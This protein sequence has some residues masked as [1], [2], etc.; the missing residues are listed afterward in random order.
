MAVRDASNSH[1]AK[2]ASPVS[3]SVGKLRGE[4]G[5][6]GA[7]LELL[8]FPAALWT[9]DRCACVFNASA[10]RLL[11]YSEDDFS[12]NAA[13][14]STRLHPQDRA[15]FVNAWRKIENGQARVSYGY[16]FLPNHA[17]S[18]IRLRE[19]LFA[20][21]SP[22]GSPAVWS[23]YQ[24]DDGT[25][26]ETPKKSL[27]RIR[28]DLVRD[29]THEIGSNLQA[30]GGEVD[31]LRLSGRLPQESAQVVHRGVEQ[32]RR[33]V[34]DVSEYIAPSDVDRQREDT[35]TAILHVLHTVASRLEQRGIRVKVRLDDQLP[36]LPLGAVFRNAFK[37]VIEFTYTL[38]PTGGDLLVEAAS[39]R[40]RDSRY[41]E[42][43][44]INV[45]PTSLD[46][47][48]QNVFRPYLTVNDCR[49]GLTMSL[50]REIL[51]HHRGKITFK[52]ERR[53]R[54]VFSIFIKVPTDLQR[55]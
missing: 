20:Y 52:K 55:P 44:V 18:R 8:P 17:K 51:R 5:D 50:A 16:R 45:S 9:Y 26:D 30:I 29:L 34:S 2:A 48:D 24:E 14:W 4:L 38:L 3:R 46:V 39:K 33:L 47:D 32:I 37:R 11:G 7:V 19:S 31:L 28:S 1:S 43:R 36:D 12:R 54:G 23:L 13:L 21:L 40:V 15:G 41:V 53:N 10:R 27:R 25:W 22:T 49:I 6:C 42:V 35:T